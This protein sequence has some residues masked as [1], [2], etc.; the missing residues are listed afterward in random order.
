MQSGFVQKLFLH[1][2][3]NRLENFIIEQGII[4]IIMLLTKN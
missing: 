1:R 3:L 4:I 2:W